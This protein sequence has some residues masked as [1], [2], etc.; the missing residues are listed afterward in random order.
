VACV[1]GGTLVERERQVEKVVAAS[2][3]A[4]GGGKRD[5][6]DEEIDGGDERVTGDERVIVGRGGVLA[7]DANLV[8]S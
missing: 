5:G 3:Q 4:A 8:L 6:E 7:T 2:W 1:L